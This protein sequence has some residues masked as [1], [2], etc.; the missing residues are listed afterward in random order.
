[1]A[2]IKQIYEELNEFVETLDIREVQKDELVSLVSAAIE[3]VKE[4]AFDKGFAEGQ[5][6]ARS[7]IKE[8]AEDLRKAV[9]NF[10]DEI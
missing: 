10:I 1:M 7:D 6:T 9:E 2:N 4:E 8:S 3:G 5:D